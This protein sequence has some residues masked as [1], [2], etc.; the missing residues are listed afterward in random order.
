MT[1]CFFAHNLFVLTLWM[2]RHAVH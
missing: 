1:L 2:T